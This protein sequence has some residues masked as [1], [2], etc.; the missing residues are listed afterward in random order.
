MKILWL[1]GNPALF[2]SKS[3]GYNNGGWIGAL[4]GLIVEQPNVDLGICFFF[5]DDCFKTKIDKTTYYPINLYSTKSEKIK[6]N[7]FYEKYDDVEIKLILKV[8]DDFKPDVIHIWGTELSFGLIQKYVKI[9]TIIHIQGILAPVINSLFI[10]ECS[11]EYYITNY[12]KGIFK[13]IFNRQTL[14]VWKHNVAREKEILR[15]SQ[16]VMGRTH[17]D[18]GVLSLLASQAQY[19]V[20]NELLRPE[21]Y[22]SKSWKKP[23]RKK[24]VITSTISETLYKGYDLILK[25]AHLLKQHTNIEFEWNVIGV[26]EFD[27]VENLVQLRS[28]DLNINLKGIIGTN[29]LINELLDSDVYAHTSYIDNSPNSVC[30]AQMLGL[31]IIST[32]VGG[33]SSLIEDGKTGLLVASNEPHM[34]ATYILKLYHDNDLSGFLGGNSRAVAGIRHNSISIRNDLSSIYNYIGSK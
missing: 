5:K 34:L 28:V 24:F 19:L 10:P 9:P 13:N 7:L 8:I 25:T 21:F 1:S 4:E 14:R 15:L 23:Q 32:N 30:E 16:F 2:T 17:W 29:E 12:G 33:I 22:L 26:K 3:K 18:K 27:F 20:C 6:H 31:P 11:K